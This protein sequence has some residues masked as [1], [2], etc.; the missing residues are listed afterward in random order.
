MD[1]EWDS[2]QRSFRDTVREFLATHLPQD[3]ESQAH[4]PAS[5]VQAAFSKKFCAQLA[6]AG[7]LV[8]HWPQQWGG[9]DADPWAAFILAEEMWAAGEPRGGQYMNVNWIGPTLMRH[10]SQE[11][12]ARYIPP[13]QS[14]ARVFQN[15][16]R[17]PTL[18]HCARA[19]RS[20]ARTITSAARRSGLRMQGMPTPVSCWR[21]PLLERMASQ[22]SSSR[23]RRP[24]SSCGR[25][26]V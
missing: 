7:L 5:E 14:G 21:E 2:E 26:P 24:A 19:P 12:Q 15:R 9:R 25:F 4:G 1:F 11:Q 8:P 22:S 3:W 10:G 23:C 6:Q 16:R 17:G 20:A 13:R 18:P